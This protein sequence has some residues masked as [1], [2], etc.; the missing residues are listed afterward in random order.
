M[1]L[2]QAFIGI[3][4]DVIVGEPF[5]RFHPVI[6]MG[7]AIAWIEQRLNRG[8]ARRLKGIFAIALLCLVNL[9]AWHL[10]ED[11]LC[12]LPFHNLW[13]GLLIGWLLAGR[14]LYDHGA[15]VRE[16]LQA[17]DL[18][19]ARGAVAKMCGRDVANLDEPALSRATI[20]SLAENFSDGFIA[21]LFWALILGL[22]GIATY[23]L[24]NT[25]D[26]MIGHRDERHGE[27]GFGAARLDDLVNWPAARL[28]ALL[29]A[30]AAALHGGSL[31]AIWRGTPQNATRHDS[32]NAGWPEAAMALGLG[33]AL[34]GPRTYDGEVSA[35]EWINPHGRT[36]A[37]AADIE[38]AL[39][40]YRT[41]WMM[42]GGLVLLF[43]IV[44]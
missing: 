18:A 32:P 11:L 21:P 43:A 26:S 17:G 16:A 23:K 25:A 44:H 41:T 42:S 33:L 19:G 24:I 2:W 1:I 34:G 7:Q 15:A 20:E 37:D 14:S 22:P 9:F 38:A 36:E 35:H 5:I 29:L 27:F 3:V 40:L 13:I 8:E 12:H 31:S 10:V 6:L 28:A 4:A 30:V 39:A